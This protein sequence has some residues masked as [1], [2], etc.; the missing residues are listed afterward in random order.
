MNF[1]ALTEQ[2]FD[3]IRKSYKEKDSKKEAQEFLSDYFDVS[4]RTVRNW[5]NKLEVSLMGKNIVNPTKIMTY[6]IETSRV[7]AKLF[8]TGKTYINY[9]QIRGEPSIISVSWR[10]LGKE[11]VHHLK[12]DMKTHSPE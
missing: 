10:W 12:W 4:E 3:L 2:D 8:W 11:E 5:A 1:N 6:D 9:K 7:S